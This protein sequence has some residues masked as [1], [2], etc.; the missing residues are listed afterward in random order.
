[1]EGIA[2]NIKGISK[3]LFFFVLI[4]FPSPEEKGK[5]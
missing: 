5:R 2:D 4:L 3:N 1:M